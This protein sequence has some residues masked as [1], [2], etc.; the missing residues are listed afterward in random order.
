MRACAR[1]HGRRFWW[2]SLFTVFLLQGMIMWFVSLVV[3][4]G[5]ASRGPRLW[6]A[7]CWARWLLVRI[8]TLLRDRGGPADGPLQIESAE[9][10]GRVMDRGLWRYTRHPNYF[11]DFCVWWGLYR[12]LRPAGAGWTLL[13][14]LLMSFLLLKVSGVSLLEQDLQ[15]RRPGY[16]EYQRRTNAFFPGPPRG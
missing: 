4:A 10:A 15:D 14:P 16:P 13:S 8:G 12:S 7:G 1:H 6:A 2:I 3:Q 9:S 5:M 11:G